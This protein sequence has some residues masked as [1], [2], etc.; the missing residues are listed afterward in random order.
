MKKFLTN[1]W[2]YVVTAILFFTLLNSYHN[3]QTL[4]REIR[5]EQNLVNALNDSVRHY[6]NKQGLWV[7]EKLTLQTTISRLEEIK[8]SLSY[9]QQRLLEYI[10]QLEQD[11]DVIAAALYQANLMIDSLQHV[12]ETIIGDSTI[13]FKDT[14]EHLEYEIL[15]DNVA[16]I[17]DDLMPNLYFQKLY[18]PNETFVEFHWRMHK[19]NYPIAFSV[20]HTNPFMQTHNVESYVIPEISKP[21]IL[22]TRW[23]MVKDVA[24][25]RGF[26]FGVAAGVVITL[27]LN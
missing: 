1:N 15:V 3:N 26:Y 9:E 10:Q 18:F 27:I 16:L 17:Q 14:Q 4:K 20:T 5:Q 2:I 7:V 22:P 11:K 13:T 24:T 25:S 12:G 23:E 8:G 21:E 6:Q 19:R